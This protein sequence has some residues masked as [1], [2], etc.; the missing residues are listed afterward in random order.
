VKAGRRTGGSRRLAEPISS[1]G[2]DAAR[3][4][5][6]GSRAAVDVEVAA[7]VADLATGEPLRRIPFHR[8][9][10][11]EPVAAASPARRA[12]AALA[13]RSRRCSTVA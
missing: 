8:Q 13:I 3:L 11:A 9:R 10:D 4:P 7:G 12:G 5:N 2:D 1:D 6:A